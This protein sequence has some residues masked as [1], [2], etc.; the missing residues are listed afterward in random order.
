VF[1]GELLATWHWGHLGAS[2]QHPAEGSN[3]KTTATVNS[4]FRKN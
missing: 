3:V 4:E 1:L 2:Q